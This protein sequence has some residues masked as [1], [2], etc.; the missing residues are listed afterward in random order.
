M[1][2]TAELQPNSFESLKQ[3]DN[4]IFV[5]H[6]L[7]KVCSST[8]Y[9]YSIQVAPLAAGGHDVKDGVV[10]HRRQHERLDVREALDKSTQTEVFVSV[11]KSTRI[12]RRSGDGSRRILDPAEVRMLVKAVHVQGQA[13]GLDDFVAVAAAI[14]KFKLKLF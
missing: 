10:A 14:L 12:R 13:P 1:C 6:K 11:E 9:L 8:F 3:S 4:F 5:V 7:R 2:S